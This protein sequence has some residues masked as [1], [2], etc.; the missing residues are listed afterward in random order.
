[1]YV[2]IG[3]VISSTVVFKSPIVLADVGCA[4]GIWQRG[5]LVNC[6]CFKISTIALDAAEKITLVTLHGSCI[7]R[8]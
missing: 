3:M 5:R 8:Y 2:C 7:C 1:M 6:T 4:A